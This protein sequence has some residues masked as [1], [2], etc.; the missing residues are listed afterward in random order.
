MTFYYLQVEKGKVQLKQT[1]LMKFPKCLFLKIKILS[2]G[3][4]RV[5]RCRFPTV[6]C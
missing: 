2:T 4:T 1:E 3:L 6:L 5:M